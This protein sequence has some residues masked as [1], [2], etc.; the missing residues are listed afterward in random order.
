MKSS[1]LE[2]DKVENLRYELPNINYFE[3]RPAISI[4]DVSN[5]N[6]LNISL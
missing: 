3:N 2:K 4:L 5:N 6:I 1:S